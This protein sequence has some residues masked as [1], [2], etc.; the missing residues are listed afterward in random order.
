MNDLAALFG[1]SSKDVANQKK[2]TKGKGK[3]KAANKEKKEMKS[4][5]QGGRY[6]LP[7]RIRSGHVQCTLTQEQFEGKTLGE[8]E[9]K[10]EIRKLYPELSGLQFSLVKFSNEFTRLQETMEKLAED[11][12]TDAE[13]GN[14]KD[15]TAEEEPL[16]IAEAAPEDDYEEGAEEADAE[17]G[18]ESDLDEG[19][20]EKEENPDGKKTDETVS[21]SGGCW[22]K[23]DIQYQEVKKDQTLAF[24]VT[25]KVGKFELEVK[26]ETSL[27][28]IRTA[29]V[30]EHP[31][32]TGCHFCYDEKNNLLFPYMLGEAEIKGK[33]YSLPVQIGYLDQ[34]ETFTGADFG[35]EELEH[36]T[37]EEIR[38]AYGK[39]HPEF[40]N[41]LFI[42][43]AERNLL[44]PVLEF[45]RNVGNER[46]S[47]PILVR[48]SGF[49][50]VVEKEDLKGAESATLEE[51]RA[52]IERV[53]PEFS[54]ERTEMHYD[55][56]NFVIPVLKGSRKGVQII[57]ERK[58]QGFYVVQG[59]DGYNYRIEQMPYGCFDCR[60]D[61]S[62]ADFRM[63]EKKISY[64]ILRD[65]VAFFKINPRKE[66]AVQIFYD[67][68][69][70]EYE[71]YYPEQ[72]V[73][74]ASVVFTRSHDMESDKVLV[75]DIHSH[76]TMK[77]FFSSID[78][79]DEKGTRLFMVFGNLDKEE[80]AY[81]LRAGIAGNYKML[82]L[83]DVF[84]MEDRT[85]EK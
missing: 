70:G 38:K 50:M 48:G 52:V 59:R 83:S 17:Q 85:N 16:D 27:E 78:D 44:F 19:D 76:G 40:E 20:A 75:M 58:N 65:V 84:E 21:Q 69:A 24:P 13:E 10:A 51:I 53:Y 67:V 29:W 57:S 56:R 46:I 62:D 30:E 43:N 61:G 11:K 22:V 33:K 9:I 26:E 77:A 15:Q 36:V 25:V 74:S 80:V 49:T 47:L 18:D 72:Q 1:I 79:H 12:D 55:E 4:A 34:Q 42:Y 23:L 28:E 54:K 37:M 81:K 2:D 60:E 64:G 3:G 41:A 66:A 5:K 39:K 71:I 32:Y 8:N 6:P 45:K 14:V 7:V 82:K 63:T 35:N 68:N 73:T 31:E